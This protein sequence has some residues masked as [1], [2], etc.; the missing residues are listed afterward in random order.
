[1]FTT[2]EQVDNLTGYAVT[3]EV[4]IMAQAI[5]ESYIGRTESEINTPHDQMLLARATAYQAAYMRDN[6]STIFEQ[7]SL[8]QT[9][10]LGQSITFKGGDT[11]APW[12]APLAVL[13]CKKLSWKRMFSVKTGPVFNRTVP[14]PT[15][16]TE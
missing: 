5:I 8:A 15:W 1:M 11:T 7:M 12:V 10:Q 4:V 14:R 3:Q 16:E 6:M 13:A 9:A 2:I